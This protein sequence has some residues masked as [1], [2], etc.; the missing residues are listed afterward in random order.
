MPTIEPYK[1]DPHVDDDPKGEISLTGTGESGVLDIS[2]GA[3]DGA[4]SHFFQCS[5]ID[6]GFHFLAPGG[7]DVG[8]LRMTEDGLEFSGDADESAAVFLESLKRL[9]A[10]DTEAM[11]NK[12]H[13]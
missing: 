6:T 9:W 3:R 5:P 8:C 10:K 13:E 7:R 11:R 4:Q 12:N 1:F 2:L